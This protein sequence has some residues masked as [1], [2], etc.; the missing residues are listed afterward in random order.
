MERTG[1]GTGEDYWRRLEAASDLLI[2]RLHALTLFIILILLLTVV[3]YPD[4]AA[5]RI[6]V[7]MVAINLCFSLARWMLIRNPAAEPL[8]FASMVLDAGVVIVISCMTART[9][10]DDPTMAM[11]ISSHSWLYAIIGVRAIRF[12]ARDIIAMGAIAVAA[13]WVI[14]W[15][16][17]AS[18]FALG[19]VIDADRLTLAQASA[20]DTTVSLVALTAALAFAVRRAREA[21]LAATGKEEAISR[22]RAAEAASIAKSEFLANMSH[23][24]RTPMNGVIGMTD[25]LAS[26]DLTH[27]QRACV[28]VIQ[29]SG[30]ALLTI[31][32]DILDFS[33]IEAGRIELERAP[34]SVRNAIEDVATLI[35]ASAAERGVELTVRVAPDLPDF[36]VGDGGRFRQIITNLVGNAA[37]FTHQGSIFV[38]AESIA[39]GGVKI[40]IE[41]TGIGIA[42]EKL[43]RI[44]EKFEQADNS[45]TRRYGGTGLGLAISKQLIE[46]MGGQISVRSVHGAGT[47]FSFA[48]NLPPADHCIES[49][50][51]I[52]QLAGKRALIVDDIAVNIAI[53]E[54]YLHVHAVETVSASSAAAAIDLL[55]SRAF[56]FAVLDYQ[57]PEMDGLALL[58]ALRRAPHAEGLPVLMLTS[59][60]DCEPIKAFANLGA[61]TVT[62]PIRRDEWFAALGRLLTPRPERSGDGQPIEA[63]LLSQNDR[64]VRLLLVEDNEV[65][66]MV[67]KMMLAGE[68]FEI[69]E[70]TD[71]KAA[72]A[73]L[74][75]TKCDIVLMDVSMP[76]M[77]GLEATR[78]YRLEETR[79]G[80]C[81]APIIGLTAHAMQQ[82][83]DLCRD[84][85]MDDHLAKPVR[86]DALLA[87][88][89]RGLAAAV[90]GE[91]AA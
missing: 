60:D 78:A 45:T 91:R 67:V 68:G 24:I 88:I 62:K 36:Y 66:R 57:M 90:A 54:E 72:L 61:R 19:A 3:K 33:K 1:V 82:D 53:L 40:S 38:S 49:R 74:A 58:E 34:F 48:I 70:A 89:R 46:L 16:A 12:R 29:A 18:P 26:T 14:V 86:K 32:N 28:D 47:T 64:P 21:A 25:V 81:R 13:W 51:A 73:M 75:S 20:I 43:D 87:A 50:P 11:T 7:A 10:G 69:T 59:V 41:D 5:T 9:M 79:N 56:D 35:S 37:K 84:A 2:V 23:E 6:A 17:M 77:D 30:G 31:I 80:A 8:A 65:N 27:K 15:Y 76:V 4:P 83:A 52:V 63:S 55:S 39:G 85:G 71:G 22:A 44:F 42:P